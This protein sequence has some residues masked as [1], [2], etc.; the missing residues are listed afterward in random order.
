MK[1]QEKQVKQDLNL[2]R[3][4]K[5]LEELMKILVAIFTG[6]EEEIDK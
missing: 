1:R 4:P 5:D 6:V 3:V 2:Y